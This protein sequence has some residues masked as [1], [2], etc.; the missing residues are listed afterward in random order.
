[1]APGESRQIQGRTE[2]Q[3]RERL[4]EGGVYRMLGLSA[5]F[6]RGIRPSHPP[7]NDRSNS[8]FPS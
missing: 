8:A 6:E 5:L 2:A 4:S 1:M 7:K 3:K